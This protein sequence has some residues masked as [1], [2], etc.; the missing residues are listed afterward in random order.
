M[1]HTSKSATEQWRRRKGIN[2]LDA[3]T[4]AMSK[5]TEKSLIRL[6]LIIIQNQTLNGKQRT[7]DLNY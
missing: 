1:Q 2:I 3:M 4:E 7:F 6:T 5:Q